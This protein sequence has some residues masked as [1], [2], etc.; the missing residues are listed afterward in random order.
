MSLKSFLKT[1]KTWVSNYVV[2]GRSRI[3]MIFRRFYKQQH[4]LTSVTGS[5]RYPELFEAA[6]INANAAVL[7]KKIL[8][9]GCSTGEECF[10]LQN[11]FPESKIIGVDINTSNIKTATRKNKSP[12]IKFLF[13]TP[14]IIHEEGKYDLIFCLSVLCR[15]EDTKFVEN[16]EKI[17]P[18]SKFEATVEMLAKELAVGG[19]MVVYNS[20]FR[21]EDTQVFA[22]DNFEIVSTP[23]V[24][25]SG[26]VFKF[27]KNCNR[28]KELHA[29]CIYRKTR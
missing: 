2:Y 25:D 6:K 16:C 14:E 20:N 27:D 4:Q 1:G 13:S 21:F 18:F 23:R 10:S 28:L 5:N 3:D 26:F 17:Y 11:Y 12:N 29:H 7:H 15:W 24:I 19:L 8:S 22:T 9:F